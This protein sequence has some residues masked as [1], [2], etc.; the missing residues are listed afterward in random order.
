MK[1]KLLPALGIQHQPA[2][3]NIPPYQSRSFR[4]G[5]HRPSPSMSVMPSQSQLR[6]RQPSGGGNLPHPGSIPVS[7]PNQSM[8][9]S[10]SNTS[11]HA[12]AA[13]VASVPSHGSGLSGVI[14]DPLSVSVPE[15]RSMQRPSSTAYGSRGQPESSRQELPAQR[16]GHQRMQSAMPNLQRQEPRSPIQAEPRRVDPPP[17]AAAP[18]ASS[19]VTSPSPEESKQPQGDGPRLGSFLE[20]LRSKSGTISSSQADFGNFGK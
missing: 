18:V 6:P 7:Q 5:F 2:K 1:R 14:E 17:P 16:Y 15:S 20:M 9:S 10:S 3:T 4:G 12:L 13:S 19:S 8:L 11:S